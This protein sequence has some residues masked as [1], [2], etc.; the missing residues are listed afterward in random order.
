[1]STHGTPV[2]DPS[3][4][5]RQAER[6][7]TSH[8]LELRELPLTSDSAAE[9]P[10]AA[11]QYRAVERGFYEEPPTGDALDQ[12]LG[13]S[14]EDGRRFLG[15]YPQDADPAQTDPVG[16]IV[17]FRK[18]LH[19]GGGRELPAWLVS[20]VTVAPTHRR[21]GILRSLMTV[22][23]QDAV[24]AGVPVAALTASE[25]AIY[26]RFGYGVSSSFR[27]VQ[28]DVRGGLPLRGP[29]P[30]GTVRLVEPAELEE[31][32]DQLYRR[33]Y[34]QT[35][36]SVERTASYRVQETDTNLHRNGGKGTGL[37]AAVHHDDD[38]QPRGFVTY[39]FSGWD[40]SPKTMEVQSLITTTAQS[41]RALWRFLGSLDLIERISWEAGPDDGLLEAML[42]DRRRVRTTF[43]QDRLWL[44]ILDVPAALSARPWSQDGTVTLQVT[45][46][47]GW[48]EGT[49]RVDVVGGEAAVA[50][51]DE[52]EADLSLDVAE[53]SGVW[54]GGVSPEVLRQAA[55]V[56]EHRRGAAVE[57]GR[58]LAS[59]R[60]VH[61]ITGF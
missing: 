44:R 45:D 23:L 57:L 30:T 10:A 11:R 56:T 61:S 13:L 43:A 42:E 19:V 49:W 5:R 37:Y 32:G 34:L 58:M 51:A 29:E 27:S 52:A 53:L 41:H 18:N 22:C 3:D 59:D 17:D 20:N 16:T 35:P 12:W 24:D 21:R 9:N 28:V 2:P 4:L 33:A 50:R 7:L 47:L 25:G 36:G 54:L 48:A 26:G 8:G 38:G 40:A 1:M 60:P 31:L 46:S 15:V 14:R 6:R 55:V 39:R